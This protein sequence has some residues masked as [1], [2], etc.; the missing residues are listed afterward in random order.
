MGFVA[1][2]SELHGMSSRRNGPGK[3][4]VVVLMVDMTRDAARPVTY[5]IRE[6]FQGRKFRYEKVSAGTPEVLAG[7]IKKH[8]ASAFIVRD[9]NNQK[10]VFSVAE[11]GR[12]QRILPR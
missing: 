6:Q 11:D 8:G 2:R 9:E 10:V 3:P 1:V 7:L 5:L 4:T 12:Q